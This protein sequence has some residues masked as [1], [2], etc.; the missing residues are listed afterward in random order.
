MAF[1]AG[2]KAVTAAVVAALTA[3]FV[4]L[5]AHAEPRLPAS[6][7]GD[8]RGTD[9]YLAPQGNGGYDVTKYDVD[10]S[11]DAKTHGIAQARV[12]ITAQSDQTLRQFTLDARSGLEIAQVSVNGKRATFSHRGDKLIIGGFGTVEGDATFT[13]AVRYS[14]D[15]IPIKDRSGRG[16]YG[17]LPTRRGSVTYTEPTG[18]STWLP[19]ND[20]FYDKARWQMTLSAPLGL[21]GVST[22]TFDG[23]SDK[24]GRTITR[25][26]MDT[27]TQPYTQVVAFDRFDYSRKPIAGIPAFTAVA[28]GSG[29]SVDQMHER[30][31]RSLK[32]LVPRLGHYPFASTGAIVVSGAD[33]AMET[34]GRPTY[35]AGS[36]NTSMATVVQCPGHL[37]ARGV[38]HVPGER[39]NSTAHRPTAQRHRPRAVRVGRLGRKVARPVRPGVA[40]RPDPALPAQHDAVLPRAGSPPYAAPDP[41]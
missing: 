23:R 28:R 19:S 38:R 15:P 21:L 22:G 39:R 11:Y 30:T 20:V 12:L 27:P 4:S 33:S 7:K 34:A 9:P 32:W 17:W 16:K 13:V 1:P 25:W 10:L 14:G 18:T 3:G 2:V 29:V 24:G 35:S 5:P 8:D 36:W 40:A 31:D 26:T 37:A 41:W 6:V